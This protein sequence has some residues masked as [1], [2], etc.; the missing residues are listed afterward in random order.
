ME[1]VH[2]DENKRD[3]SPV[4]DKSHV[5]SSNR[6][7]PQGKC[8]AGGTCQGLFFLIVPKYIVRHSLGFTEA[9]VQDQFLVLLG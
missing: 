2:S 5:P 6:I 7:S 4:T 1:E 3:V 8:G 9:F